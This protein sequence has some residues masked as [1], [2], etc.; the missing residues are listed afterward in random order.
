MTGFTLSDVRDSFVADMTRSFDRLD[1]STREIEEAAAVAAPLVEAAQQQAHLIGVTLHLI[2]G[3]TGLV[4]VD[5]M[6]G[7]THA[8]EDLVPAASE[9]LKT[10]AL[11]L[12]RLRA[13]AA[14]WSEGG[15]ALRGMLE[16]ELEARSQD[17]VELQRALLAELP[18]LAGGPA[19]AQ[20]VGGG[21]GPGAAAPAAPVL[22]PG[23]D[24]E[25]L[26][27]FRE[28]AREVVAGLRGH[29]AE[30]EARPDDLSTTI[31]ASRLLHLL[32]GAA[33]S[34]QLEPLTQRVTR[35]YARFEEVVE[36]AAPVDRDTLELLRGGIA[37]V[38]AFTD[39]EAAPPPGQLSQMEDDDSPLA[40]FRE[41]AAKILAAA[42]ALLRQLRAADPG[43]VQLREGIV[44]QI[45]R[46]FHRL[47]GSALVVGE[48]A[49]AAW[50]AE[51]QAT[52][53]RGADGAD[54]EELERA[55]EAIRADLPGAA[56]AAPA[57]AAGA[58]RP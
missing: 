40:V 21:A 32:K 4:S 47:K 46:H 38:S 51:A 39:P 58:A 11:H 3:T 56:P 48:E 10:I 29:L 34:V 50:A 1:E 31:A 15:R 36:R 16:L 30:L 41:E 2:A 55:I 54:P 45:E 27:V 7:A 42:E 8:L 35:L 23:I 37:E 9:S 43:S 5:S 24:E 26:E 49:V 20:E 33:A 19:A 12:G 53:E 57:A 14:S 18:A 17:A 52:C 22:P 13:I 44:E 28:E 25:L 6:Q